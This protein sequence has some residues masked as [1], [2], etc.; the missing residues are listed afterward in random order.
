ML[1]LFHGVLSSLKC[2]GLQA[3]NGFRF[4]FDV[5][6]DNFV[7]SSWISVMFD[8]CYC[9]IIIPISVNRGCDGSLYKS[10]SPEFLL[11]WLNAPAVLLLIVEKT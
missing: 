8:L 11:W 2:L 7:Y 6:A 9:G 3:Y 5:C 1:R 4:G 10:K